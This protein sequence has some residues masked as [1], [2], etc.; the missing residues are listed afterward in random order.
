VTNT[1]FITNGKLFSI[2]KIASVRGVEIPA[3]Y[4]SPIVGIFFGG[5][6]LFIG[7][8]LHGFSLIIGGIGILIIALSIFQLMGRKRVFSI[9]LGIGGNEVTAYRSTNRDIVEKIIQAINQA[10]I[11]RG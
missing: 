6:V 2:Q 3:R 4:G 1:A 7:F 11:S 5:I 9:V 10:I 8:P